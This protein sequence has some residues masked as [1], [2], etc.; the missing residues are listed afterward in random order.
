M[1]HD[2]GQYGQWTSRD[3]GL[4]EFAKELPI[5]TLAE[6]IL[7]DGDGQIKALI[8]L[9][10]NP[11]LSAPNGQLMGRALQHLTRKI[12]RRSRLLLSP[13]LVEEL[14]PVHNND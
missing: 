1:T 12:T 2:T 11:A 10:G 5:S 7:S 13:V 4:P 9:A 3:R 8:T 6:D 14:M